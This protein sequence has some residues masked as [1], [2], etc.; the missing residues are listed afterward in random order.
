MRC[1][2]EQAGRCAMRRTPDAPAVGRGM[3]MDFVRVGPV[4]AFPENTCRVV[5]LDSGEPVLVINL[6]GDL[7]ALEGRCPGGHEFANA[8]VVESEGTRVL[9]PSHG[10]EID[11]QHGICLADPECVLKVYDVR[12]ENG[13][14]L[15]A[16]S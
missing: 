4:E 8:P 9:C 5:T 1:D 14:L 16:R 15:I 11:L 3:E 12:V 10:W 2:K 7:H 13:E 6:E